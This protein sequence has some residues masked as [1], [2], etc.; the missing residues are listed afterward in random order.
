VVVL[1]EMIDIAPS[2]LE[3]FATYIFEH[4]PAID[5]IRFNAVNTTPAAIGF[6][7]QRHN[8]KDTFMISLPATSDEYLATIGKSTRAKLRSRLNNIKKNVPNFDVKF[9]ANDDID[10]DTVRRIARLSEQRIHTRGVKL[11]HDVARMM[12]LARECGVV[13]VLLID[14]RMCAGSIN[15]RIGDSVFGEV[16][17]HDSEYNRLGVGSLCVYYT[18][19]ES[20]RT[21]VKKFYLGGGQFGFK[22]RMLG[23]RLD[24][25]QLQIYRSHQRVFTN[26]DL[27]AVAF[28][29]GQTR[30]LKRKLHERKGTLLADLVFKF[31]HAYKNKLGK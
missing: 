27:A 3:R 22:E 19:C 29:H 30:R 31:F 13:T 26:L 10:E 24:M 21:G 16:L 4:F 25:D 14:G 9:L 8:A 20:I 17:A 1:N 11:R 28:L 6:P 5:V 7:V 18:I 23:E 15:Y 2:G 12:A